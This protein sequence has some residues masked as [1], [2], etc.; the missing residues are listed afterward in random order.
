MPK[1]A[2]S[3]DGARERTFSTFVLDDDLERRWLPF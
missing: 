1:E 2:G 3:V